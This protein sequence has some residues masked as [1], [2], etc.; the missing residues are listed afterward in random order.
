MRLKKS[1]EEQRGQA[2]VQGHTGGGEREKETS[3]PRQWGALKSTVGIE[4]CS[5]FFPRPCPALSRLIPDVIHQIFVSL[6]RVPRLP[7]MPLRIFIRFC[8]F[9]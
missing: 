2:Q 7:K 9:K 4:M 3:P 5:G 8:F 6:L 1:G